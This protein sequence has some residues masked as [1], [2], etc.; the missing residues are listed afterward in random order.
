MKR[1]ISIVLPLGTWTAFAQT[2]IAAKDRMVTVIS[3]DGF[4][5]S[6]QE[7]PKQPVPTRRRKSNQNQLVSQLFTLEGK[8]F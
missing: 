1:I 5:G 3:L 2:Q 8:Y 4:L 6:T 7:D